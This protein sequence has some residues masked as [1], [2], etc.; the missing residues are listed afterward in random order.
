MQKSPV[1]RRKRGNFCRFSLSR[2][3]HA[4]AAIERPPEG[5]G[6]GLSH[7]AEP[8]APHCGHIPPPF[9]A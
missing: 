2:P 8:V 9:F 3:E 7:Q 1:D 6:S 5:S 4:L